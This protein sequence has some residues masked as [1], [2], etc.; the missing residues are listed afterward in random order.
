MRKRVVIFVLCGL[1][2]TIISLLGARYWILGDEA[3]PALSLGDAAPASVE[4]SVAPPDGAGEAPV[5]AALNI[6]KVTGPVEHRIKDRA[7]I[8]ARVGDVLSQQHSLRTGGES[9]AILSVGDR[10]RL[11]ISPKTKVSVREIN[12]KIHT[13]R[14]DHGRL[15][16]D[17][18][19]DG[20][21]RIRVESNTGATAEAME[22]KFTVMRTRTAMAVATETG[23][24]DLQA[25][26]RKVQLKAGEQ[27]VVLDDQPP[28]GP[29]AIPKSV[30]IKIAGLT[31]API[32]VRGN[33]AIVKGSTQP[34]NR[35]TIR[36]RQVRVDRKGLFRQKVALKQGLNRIQI[37]FEA[38]AGRRRTRVV[39]YY[40]LPPDGLIEDIKLRWTKKR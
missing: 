10:S 13:F 3:L 39:E 35:V 37:V 8:A 26:G 4:Q 40:A 7:W 38:P 2:L 29:M 32:E 12:K 25:A 1:C 11:T 33:S 30:L 15:S 24:V 21:R 23:S 17:Y 34:G 6:V 22:G 20:H 28:T 31:E 27:S 19:K 16:V 18:K 5:G 9:S 14:L 36:G